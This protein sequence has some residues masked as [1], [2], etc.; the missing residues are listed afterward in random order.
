M[1]GFLSDD[2]DFEQYLQET[3]CKVKV[4]PASIFSDDYEAEFGERSKAM[5]SLM[6][7]TKL[8]NAISFR[9]GEVTVWAGYNGHKKSMLTGQVMLDLCAQ[10]EPCLSISLEMPPR[11]TLGR[12]AR[13]AIASPLP[14]RERWEQFMRWSDG[15]MWLF[16]HVGRL[17]PRMCLAVCR[18][19][20]GELKGRHVFIDSLMRVCQSEESLD[21]QKQLIGDLCDLAK[22]TGLHIHLIAHCKKP[23]GQDG[24]S[25]PPTKYDIRG[26]SSVSDQ[27]HNVILVWANK[28]KQ[29]ESEK[30]EPDPKVMAQ[31][32]SI[33]VIDKQ[34]NGGTEGR[35]GLAF[36]ARTL[37]HVDSAE[38]AVEPYPLETLL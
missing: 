16:D 11:R 30:R 10:D 5:R 9:E 35:F 31:T 19:F 34:R 36:D 18:Y 17:N 24:E 7:S 20:S 21:E 6:T 12:M 22:E 14:S 29:A 26:S 13:Q 25:R 32:D 1:A 33:V 8:R 3:D 23:P 2:I 37:R 4:R 27:A 28:A 15:R 38:Q